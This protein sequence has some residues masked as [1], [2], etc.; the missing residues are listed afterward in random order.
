MPSHESS[1]RSRDTNSTRQRHGKNAEAFRAVMRLYCPARFAPVLSS[2]L[3]SLDITHEAG[4]RKWSRDVCHVVVDVEKA[5]CTALHDDP[6][7]LA[8]FRDLFV[9]SDEFTMPD[10]I[11]AEISSL[12]QRVGSAFIR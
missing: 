8:T 1:C 3:S 7:L 2:C 9:C 4:L 12:I 10:K 11:D 6:K 5:V